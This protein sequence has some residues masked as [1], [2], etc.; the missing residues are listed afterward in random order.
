VAS[1]RDAGWGLGNYP[2]FSSGESMKTNRK[3][4]ILEG[5][6][7]S[8]ARIIRVLPGFDL[9]EGI[10]EA[11][12]SLGIKSGAVTSCIGSLQRAS[13]MIAVPLDNKIGAGYSDPRVI[14]GPLELLSAQGTIGLEEGGEVAI[15]LHGAVSDKEG[16]VHGGHLVKGGNPVLITCEVVVT[17]VEGIRTAKG[18]DPEVEM[19]IFIPQRGVTK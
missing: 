15:H 9:I 10:E 14:E 6:S 18:Y 17:Q 4:I 13:L 19:N 2:P 8:R 12:Q 7:S 5:N 1:P 16:H 11:C 3:V